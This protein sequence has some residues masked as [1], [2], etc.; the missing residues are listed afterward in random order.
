MRRG[1]GRAVH[2]AERH[3]WIDGC[4]HGEVRDFIQHDAGRIRDRGDH[5]NHLV[6]DDY[7]VPSSQDL[8][9]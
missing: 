5:P 8:P 6:S 7:A 4:M 2:I 3:G 9:S 1:K